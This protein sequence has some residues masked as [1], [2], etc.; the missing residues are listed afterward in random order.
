M[1]CHS[2]SEPNCREIE[3]IKLMELLSEI[4]KHEGEIP[5][6]GEISAIDQHT[7]MLCDFCQ[8]NDVTKYSLELQIWWRDH[9]KADKDRIQA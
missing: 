5:Y 7:E 6:Y 3:S 2:Y 8:K 9:H 4:G 1:P